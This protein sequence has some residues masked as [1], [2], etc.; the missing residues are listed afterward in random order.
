L[1]CGID[2]REW[3]EDVPKKKQP[4]NKAVDK[5]VEA[6]NDDLDERIASRKEKARVITEPVI[7]I[8][9]KSNSLG[10]ALLTVALIVI[11]SIFL[12]VFHLFVSAPIKPGH[13]ISPGIWLSKCGIMAMSSSCDNAYLHIAKSGQVALYRNQEIVWQ[14]DGGSCNQDANVAAKGNCTAGLQFM[15]NRSIVVGG[16]HISTVTMA[17]ASYVSATQDLSPWPFSELPKL[18]IVAS[19][20]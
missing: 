12:Q 2:A 11:L 16:K 17:H 8:K 20:K 10:G 19:R 15:E 13:S 5:T 14:I 3:K 7:S 6:S 4:P 18:K 1:S 9:S